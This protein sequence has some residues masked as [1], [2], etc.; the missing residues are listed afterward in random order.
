MRGG[1]VGEGARRGQFF[2]LVLVELGDAASQVVDVAVRLAGGD[3]AAGLRSKAADVAETEAQ[4]TL[5]GFHRAVPFG[6]VDVDR[7]YAQAMALRILDE[8]R[9]TVKPHR[10]I[11]QHRA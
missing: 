2:E 9:G 3:Q 1:E 4:G 6:D 7:E 11:I 8:N 5:F 10:L